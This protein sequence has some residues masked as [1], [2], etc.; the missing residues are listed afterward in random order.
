M[1]RKLYLYTVLGD[2]SEDDILDYG[3]V[4][5]ENPDEVRLYLQEYTKNLALFHYLI[6]CDVLVYPLEDIPA[7][8]LPSGASFQL[9][10]EVTSSRLLLV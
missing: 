4:R 3:V 2:H 7:G 6:E 8:V 10:V 1:N 9:T 5:A